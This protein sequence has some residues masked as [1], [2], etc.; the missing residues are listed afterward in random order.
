MINRFYPDMYVD[1]ILSIPLDFLL[2][3]KKKGLILDLDNTVTEWN[4]NFII[5]EIILWFE[6]L[7]SLKIKACL[8]SN[9]N[10][11]RVLSIADQ[12]KIPFVY[13][14][15]KPFNRGYLKALNILGLSSNEVAVVGDQIFTDIWGGNRLGFFTI[16]IKPM[17]DQ[18]FP[19]TKVSR[20][21]ERRIMKYLMNS[22]KVDVRL[23]TLS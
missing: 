14:A 10:E 9:N 23:K 5:N 17:S 12:L 8:L 18:E 7:A 22:T 21:L 6:S 13:K 20:F 2:L 19:G 1:D 11:N 4:S 15:R 3:N 16:L